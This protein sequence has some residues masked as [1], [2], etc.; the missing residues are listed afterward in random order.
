MISIC[1]GESIFLYFSIQTRPTQY[2]FLSIIFQP[3]LTG[4]KNKILNKPLARIAFVWEYKFIN[5]C[6][7]IFIQFRFVSQ[8]K[9]TDS[10]VIYYDLSLLLLQL[11]FRITYSGASYMVVSGKKLNTF[12]TFLDFV[13]INLISQKRSPI[14]SNGRSFFHYPETS[15]T[16]LIL[17]SV[18]LP[19]P[20]CA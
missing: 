19:Q 3:R 5:L 18:F 16:R 4:S 6:V 12:E 11:L 10:I 8:K 20:G 9:Q 7:Y 14:I 15:H 1:P 13:I 17:T 2:V